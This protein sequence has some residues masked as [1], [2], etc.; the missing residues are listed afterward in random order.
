M[1]EKVMLHEEIA[2][3]GKRLTAMGKRL[4][5]RKKK[6]RKDTIR[7]VVSD[8]PD[9][10]KALLDLLEITTELQKDLMNDGY[11]DFSPTL[12]QSVAKLLDFGINSEL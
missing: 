9:K 1:S 8:Y 4:E 3:L 7:N 12:R 10:N 11:H 2:D 6:T 5:K